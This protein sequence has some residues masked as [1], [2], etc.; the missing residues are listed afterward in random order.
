MKLFT[1]AADH[2]CQIRYFNSDEIDDDG[3]YYVCLIV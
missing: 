1:V 3:K 2:Q